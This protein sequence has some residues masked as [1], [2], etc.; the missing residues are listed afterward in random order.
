MKAGHII[1]GALALG[2]LAAISSSAGSKS[3]PAPL[4]GPGGPSPA[5]GPIVTGCKSVDVQGVGKVYVGTTNMGIQVAVMSGGLMQSVLQ[6]Q[7]I[8]ELESIL[9]ASVTQGPNYAKLSA[10]QADDYL[11]GAVIDIDITDLDMEAAVSGGDTVMVIGT[12]TPQGIV[13]KFSLDR[14]PSSTMTISDQQ[15]I[16]I[17][18]QMVGKQCETVTKTFTEWQAVF[19]QGSFA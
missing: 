5:I 14:H 16:D 17:C 10:M 2:G 3:R 4:P 6:S 19:A 11:C 1:L 12:L 15:V 13:L 18:N 8:D 7:M 9:G